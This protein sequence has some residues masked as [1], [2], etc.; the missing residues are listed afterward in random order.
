MKT[1]LLICQTKFDENASYAGG[2]GGPTNMLH[3]K[4]KQHDGRPLFYDH[5]HIN[6]MKAQLDAVG[7]EYDK[8][9]AITN[10][11]IRKIHPDIDVMPMTSGSE[12][13]GWWSKM[14]MYDANLRLTGDVLFL[15][16]DVMPGGKFNTLWDYNS[17]DDIVLRR[18]THLDR[19]HKDSFLP[20]VVKHG[21]Q[22]EHLSWIYN[23][24]FQRFKPEKLGGL[25]R[26]YQYNIYN[27][28][29]LSAIGDE[30]FVASWLIENSDA[31]SHSE[32]DHRM[33]PHYPGLMHHY[34]NFGEPYN[35]TLTDYGLGNRVMKIDLWDQN[36]HVPNSNEIIPW[37][38]IAAVMLGG[39]WKPWLLVNDDD[40]QQ[41]YWGDSD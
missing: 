22:H 13:L 3:A 18:A 11:D 21:K 16:L 33:L 23:T 27:K 7:A 32:F 41:R 30:H 17:D 9:L 8:I 12:Y 15:D 26:W 24:S 36:K 34:Y 5:T 35:P 39:N 1:I 20:G 10:A 29:P 28:T 2:A 14:M 4:A 40:L 37:D 38:D 31:V 19:R 25:H 6:R